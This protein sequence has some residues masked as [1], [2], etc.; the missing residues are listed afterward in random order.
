MRR[1]FEGASD[2]QL[3]V[4]NAK[5]LLPRIDQWHQWFLNHRDPKNTGLVAL[6]HP[7]ESGRDNSVDWDEPFE[8]VPVEGITPYERRDLQHADADHRPTKAQYDRYLWLVEHFR[9]LGWDNQRLH[10]ASPFQV[11]DPGFNAIFIRSCD[12]IAQVAEALGET[13]IAERN[14][15]FAAKGREAM[16]SLWHDDNGQYACYDRVAGTLSNS[17]SVG[18]ILAVLA[19][20]PSH[21]AKAI[22]ARIEQLRESC[23]YLVPSHD[24]RDEHFDA[25]RY[26]RG[27]SWLIVNYLITAGLRQS[28]EHDLA[29]QIEA[30]SLKLIETS[31][32][33][34]YYDPITGEPCG[35]SSFTWTA[36]MVLEFCQ[37][38]RSA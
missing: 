2:T 38:Q 7:W 8:R 5:Q 27:P 21:R 1:L 6:I 13:E 12:D 28:N 25:K 11:V 3:A 14:R 17:V 10:D 4:Q 35:G 23:N 29:Q 15:A 37:M 20:L 24:P 31:G 16:E 33:A 26:W 36:A 34:E 30:Q 32:F 9:S 22:A 19:H 18:G